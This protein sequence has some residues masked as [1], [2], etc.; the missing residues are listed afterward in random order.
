MFRAHAPS[1]E[2][3]ILSNEL[4]GDR[5]DDTPNKKLP[6]QDSPST[7]KKSS[8]FQGKLNRGTSVP[9]GSGRVTPRSR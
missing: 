3:V 7:M 6:L 9:A 1:G 5:V 8:R 4:I 2:E